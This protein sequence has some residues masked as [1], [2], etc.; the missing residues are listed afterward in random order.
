MLILHYEVRNVGYL[1]INTLFA[2]AYLKKIV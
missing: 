2:F 1:A